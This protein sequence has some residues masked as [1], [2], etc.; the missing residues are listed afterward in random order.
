MPP[1]LSCH[2][3]FTALTSRSNGPIPPPA[4]VTRTVA[5]SNSV[6]VWDHIGREEYSAEEKR[7]CWIS[8]EK[9]GNMR[10]ER[11]NTLR[12]MHHAKPWI[13][14]GEHYFR[15]LERK[16]RKGSFQRHYDVYNAQITV[17]DEQIEQAELQVSNPEAVARLYIG[18]TTRSAA[19]ARQRGLID[20]SAAL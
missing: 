3:T 7:S 10:V 18:S 15:G 6:F 14:D 2:S 19:K 4:S 16:T 12:I 1:S 9:F 20:Q 13:D 5:F 17:F 11:N 8:A